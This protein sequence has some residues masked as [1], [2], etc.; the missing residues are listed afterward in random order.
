M[1]TQNQALTRAKVLIVIHGDKFI[2]AFS[3][4]RNIDIRFH[5]A[6]E[7]TS[8]EAEILCEQLIEELLPPFWLRIFQGYRIGL[9]AI[10][11]KTVLDAL[12]GFIS[13]SICR[14]LNAVSSG[15][16]AS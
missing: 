2:E 11:P 12:S 10:R 8:S 16:D 14:G 6:P 4:T 15:K 7:V 13:T 5:H 1:N 3:D 9:F